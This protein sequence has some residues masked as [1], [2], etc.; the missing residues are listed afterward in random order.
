MSRRLSIFQEIELAER[1]RD[2]GQ[3]YKPCRCGGN[4]I[5]TYRHREFTAST[6]IGGAPELPFHVGY[7]CEQCGMT[8]N[9]RQQKHKT[10]KKEEE[11]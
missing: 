5:P 10:T 1:E 9:F 11:G 7:H 4:I 6:P 3:D 8:Y 2:R